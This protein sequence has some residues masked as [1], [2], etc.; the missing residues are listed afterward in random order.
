MKKLHATYLVFMLAFFMLGAALALTGCA[1]PPSGVKLTPQQVAQQ[2]CPA[3]LV[4]V[5]SLSSLQGFPVTVHDDLVTAD[6]LVHAACNAGATVDLTSLKTLA[7]T[8]LPALLRV[9]EVA[10][11]DAAEHDRIVLGLTVAQIVLQGALQAAGQP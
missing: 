5:A 4:T 6:V 3:A 11:L 7:S 1:S 8:A 9:V 10:G 2:V